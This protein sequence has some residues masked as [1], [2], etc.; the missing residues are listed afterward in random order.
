[1]Q[2]IWNGH[3][4]TGG[5]AGKLKETWKCWSKAA[6]HGPVGAQVAKKPRAPGLDQ[7]MGVFTGINLHL[8]EILELIPVFLS[9]LQDEVS[10]MDVEF[11]APCVCCL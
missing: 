5:R 8:W 11:P 4:Q 6:E 3:N 7:P 10:S 9:P 2:G 1:M